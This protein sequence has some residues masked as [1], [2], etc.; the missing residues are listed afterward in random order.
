MDND[1][2]CELMYGTGALTDEEA[3]AGWHFSD[4]YCGLLIG[5]GMAEYDAESI[6]I[7]CDTE[8]N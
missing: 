8:L 3:F 1:R 5:P 4:E 2:W 6:L 7:E